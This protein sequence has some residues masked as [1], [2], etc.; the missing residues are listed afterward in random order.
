MGRRLGGTEGGGIGGG[1][2][3]RRG[4]WRVGEFTGGTLDGE[5]VGGAFGLQLLVIT[6]SSSLSLLALVTM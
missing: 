1:I 3:S 6:V 5:T 4:S 2:V